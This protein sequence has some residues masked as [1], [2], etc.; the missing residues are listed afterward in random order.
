MSGDI[1]SLFQSHVRNLKP[2]GANSQFSGL[3]PFHQDKKPS[4]SLSLN[5][6]LWKCHAGCGGGDAA[7][8]AEK[9]G[10][11]PKPY[12]KGGNGSPPPGTAPTNQATKDKPL[13][14][15][16]IQKAREW[17]TYLR[18]NFD[19][20]TRD[21]PWTKEAVKKAG[22]GYDPDTGRFI[23]VHRDSQG[24]VLNIKHGKGRGGQV[25]Y[26][27]QG[28]GQ[29]RLYP[30]HLIKDY[31]PDFVIYCEG[32]PDVVP[33]L[34]HGFQAV[35]GTNGAGS[36]PPDLRPLSKFKAVVVLMD[37]DEAGKTGSAKIADAIL[38]QCPDTEVCISYWPEDRPEG[39]DITDFFQ[40]GGI[41]DEFEEMMLKDVL[42]YQ[43]AQ[44][45]T[46]AQP[47]DFP[48]FS[49]RL[50]TERLT[51]ALRE[52]LSQA[53]PTTDA[54]DEFLIPAF[55]THWAG[56]VGNRLLAPNRLRPNVWIVLFAGSSEI[57]KSTAL[58]LAGRPHKVIQKRFDEGLK[59]EWG[60]YKA[61]RLRW[62][63]LDKGQ[64]AEIP[65]PEKP[66]AHNL[67]LP[68]DFSDAGLYMALKQN[69]ISGVI[70]A[71]EF[72]DF[73]KKLNRDY[74]AQADAFLSAYDC[75]R[76]ARQT[77]QHELEIIEEPTFSILGATTFE[78]F[79]R[80]FHAGE[81]ETGFFQRI[82]PIAISS[83]TKERKLFLQR[84]EMERD[85][86]QK[87]ASH[88]KAWLDCPGDLEVVIPPD[89]AE[90]FSGWERKIVTE[91][92]GKYGERIGP[93]I[94]RVVPGCL[95]LAMICESLEVDNPE[96]QTTLT[97]SNESLQCAQMLVEN[98]FL[99][100]V[101]Y[102]LEEEIIYGRERLNEKKVERTLKAAGSTMDRTALIRE[103]RLSSKELD[104]VI[105]TLQDKG[106]LE[107]S[108]EH[109]ERKQGG[110]KPTILYTW[111]GE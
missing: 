101:N 1:A 7:D 102:L 79:R 91:A 88:I 63:S 82:F 68:A 21:L 103:A 19:R 6:G 46:P 31:D 90:A 66:V 13:P 94:E 5:T 15:A 55:L 75:E 104:E 33:L 9:M 74:T 98:L 85:F 24:K 67:L 48:Q 109:Q 10:L 40:G 14:E 107:V 72:A 60:E 11:D 111:I 105:C 38:G 69:P 42:L 16:E 70:V 110:G 78:N 84:S 53:A 47:R 25:P 8:F 39:Y 83:P 37:N 92:R 77:R 32:E 23:Y 3:C 89:T 97:L 29:T 56:V 43:P 2:S 61:D 26:S 96:G 99:P 93:H 64:R 65:E 12:Y 34:S 87:E 49:P 108:S 71:G 100:S 18:D 80:V 41:A 106:F 44:P 36:I 30:A 73:H 58:T 95:K 20:L 86:I 4:F 59:A 52:F 35:T 62:E 57:R 22:V 17:Y 27:V 54:P 76:M 28:Y 81:T 45:E 51:P 50:D